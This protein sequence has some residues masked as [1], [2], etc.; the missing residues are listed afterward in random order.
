MARKSLVLQLA[1]ATITGMPMVAMIIDHYSET[2]NLAGMLYG[3]TSFI[4]QILIGLA[5]GAI[6][7][8]IARLIVSSP[9]LKNINVQYANMFGRFRLGW[10]EIIFISMC[11]GVGEEILFRGALQPL[12]GI[13]IT[14][15]V[16]VGIHGYISPYNWRLS[17]YGLYMTAAICLI[18]YFA[19]TEGLISAIIAHTVIDVYLLHYMQKL[20]GQIPITENHHLTDIPEDEPEE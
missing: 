1:L 3:K 14:S 8:L 18:G 12:I 16:F 9:L 10:S 5:S 4:R 6:I 19:E 15:F 17:I 7:A 2:V 11:A 13:I 20:A